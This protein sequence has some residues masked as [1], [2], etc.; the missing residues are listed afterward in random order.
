MKKRV[1]VSQELLKLCADV[2]RQTTQPGVS[3]LSADNITRVVAEC[4]E[5]YLED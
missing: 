2:L 1:L 4:L 3:T 5:S